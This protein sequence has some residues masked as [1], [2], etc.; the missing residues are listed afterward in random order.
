MC[1]LLSVLLVY[2]DI[3]SRAG[4]PLH[5]VVASRLYN[6]TFLQKDAQGSREIAVASVL[7]S[8]DCPTRTLCPRKPLA[9]ETEGRVG[10][11]KHSSHAPTEGEKTEERRKMGA[12]RDNTSTSAQPRWLPHPD[13]MPPNHTQT[14]YNTGK[15]KLW[16]GCKQR[17][18]KCA[19]T[20]TPFSAPTSK[21][22]ANFGPMIRRCAACARRSRIDSGCTAAL[23]SGPGAPTTE[24]QTRLLHSG[25][26]DSSSF[27]PFFSRNRDQRWGAPTSPPVRRGKAPRMHPLHRGMQGQ[28][29]PL[30]L[31]C[32]NR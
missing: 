14:R 29:L 8:G 32:P 25:A 21:K 22:R 10:E 5:R 13:T 9:T 12:H 17:L 1:T 6:H 23:Q 28:P 20:P 18:P 26:L 24:T 2:G 4:V 11:I 3:K 27:C 16:R 31:S 19:Q 15:K 30:G 7:C